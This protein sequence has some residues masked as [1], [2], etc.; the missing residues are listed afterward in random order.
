V[1]FAI[2]SFFRNPAELDP[3]YAKGNNFKELK[4]MLTEDIENLVAPMREKRNAISDANVRNILAK[5]NAAAQERARA[6]MADVRAKIGI[7]L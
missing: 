7:A 2:H 1:L 4:E 3:L 5:G 6:K